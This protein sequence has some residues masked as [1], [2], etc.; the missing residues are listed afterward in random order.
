MRAT[1]NIPDSLI[2]EALELSDQKNKT[3]LITKALTEY[4]RMLKREKLIKL[5]GQQILGDDFNVDLQRRSELN[6]IDNG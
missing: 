1:L 5:R 2:S 6:E 4:T 3:A